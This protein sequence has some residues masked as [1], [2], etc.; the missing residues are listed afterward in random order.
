MLKWL[1]P[2]FVS[3]VI[4]MV[5]GISTIGYIF[6]QIREAWDKERNKKEGVAKDKAS[7]TGLN[8]EALLAQ[9]IKPSERE[10]A[11]PPTPMWR[12]LENVQN[13]FGTILGRVGVFEDR[14]TKLYDQNGELREG[15]WEVKS[16]QMEMGHSNRALKTDINEVKEET[17]GVRSDL[18]E[19]K[20]ILQRVDVGGAKKR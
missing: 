14:L 1:P 9:L 12:Q 16:A 18:A 13:Q 17:A 20:I 4:P 3:F 7:G 15:L 5:M 10:G 2:W 8:V 11:E 19:L 6:Y